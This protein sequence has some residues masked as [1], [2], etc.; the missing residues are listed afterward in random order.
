MPLSLGKNSSRAPVGLDLDGGFVAAAVLSGK[1]I[2]QA[3]SVELP[4]GTIKDGEVAH[5]DGLSEALKDFF[6]ATDLPKTVRLGVANQQIVVRHLELPRIESRTE[7]DAAVRFQAGDAIAMP[8]DEAVLDYQVVGEA[9]GPEG[10]ARMRVVVVAAREEMIRRFVGAV[11][12]A[13]LKPLGIDLDA[14]ALVR[15]LGPSGGGDD[16]DGA[17]DGAGSAGDVAPGGA[18]GADQARVYCHVAGVTNLA[19]ATASDCLFTRPLS[20]TVNGDSETPPDSL[21]E[22]VRLSIDYY[23]G[24][25]EAR[26]LADLLLSGPGARREDLVAALGAHTGLPVTV[27]EPLGSLDATSLPAGE[28]PYRY[29]VAAGLALGAQA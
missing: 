24:Q 2:E 21:A 8:L 12:G 19:V 20:A 15:A 22:E 28:D 7:L 25:P 14:F 26:P 29:T 5:A 3:A 10:A 4:D 11:R 23:M 17:G 9:I 18:T 1:R 6:R 13:G 16:G 27:A